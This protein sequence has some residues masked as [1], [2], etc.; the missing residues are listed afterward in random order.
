[1]RRDVFSHQY[2]RY[3]SYHDAS[4]DLLIEMLAKATM[5]IFISKWMIGMVIKTKIRKKDA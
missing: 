5:L 4:A 1:M 3:L 2:P